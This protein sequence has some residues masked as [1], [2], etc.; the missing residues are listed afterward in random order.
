MILKKDVKTDPR[1]LKEIK[2]LQDAGHTIDI[3]SSYKKANQY[4][5]IHC[6][7]LDTLALGILLKRRYNKK[8]IYDSHE[9]YG[10]MASRTIP[11][12]QHF[13]TKYERLLLDK[14][15]HIITVNEKLEDYFKLISNKPVTIVM[16]CSEKQ[17]YSKPSNDFSIGYFGVLDGSR[18]FPDILSIGNH[19]TFYIASRKERMYKEIEQTYKLF[20]HIKFLGTIPYG[21]IMELTK[22]C[23]AILCMTNPNDL[24]M[25]IASPTK[26]FEAMACSRPVIVT[27]GTYPSEIVKANECGLTAEYDVEDVIRTCYTLAR[28]KRLYNR[29]S[30]N[31]WNASINKYNWD[32]QSKKLIKVYDDIYD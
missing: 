18:M 31:G 4:D 14:V 5:V 9:N 25:S 3:T 23:S 15:D 17:K 32:T 19:F 20:K 30:K 12:I 13:I 10:F 8:L 26:I 28:N 24:N 22:Q 7:D 21:D 2:S 27:N 1:V 29:L 6:H 16:N 11:G